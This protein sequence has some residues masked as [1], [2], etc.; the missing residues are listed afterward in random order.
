ML[1]L[2]LAELEAQLAGLREEDRLIFQILLQRPSPQFIA[3]AKAGVELRTCFMAGGGVGWQRADGVFLQPTHW[4]SLMNPP[5]GKAAVEAAIE[6][7]ME[8]G[9]GTR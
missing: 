1:E 2:Q 8:G 3:L 5:A 6:K 9:N 4:M 7:G